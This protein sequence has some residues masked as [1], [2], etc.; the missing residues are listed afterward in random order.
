MKRMHRG[1]TLI[2][3]LLVVTVIGIAGAVVVPNLMAGGTRGVQAAA[4][5]VSADILIAQN[6]GLHQRLVARLIVARHA[7]PEQQSL[8]LPAR[9]AGAACRRS[10]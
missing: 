6:V 4:R 5:I 7:Q 3:V 2:E 8:R 9:H 1:Y 10:T